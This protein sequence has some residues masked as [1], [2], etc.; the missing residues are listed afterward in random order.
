MVNTLLSIRVP[1]VLLKEAKNTAKNKGFASTQ[2]YIRYALR[3][4]LKEHKLQKSL[5]ALD[6]LRGCARHKNIKLMTKEERDAMA[7][8]LYAL[9]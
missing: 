8:A 7:R 1:A 3:E 4:Q 5:K 9:K 2:E 6:A